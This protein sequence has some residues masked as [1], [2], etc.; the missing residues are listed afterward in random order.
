[1]IVASAVSLVF[2]NVSW[3]VGMPLAFVL[4]M[5][6]VRLGMDGVAER[7]RVGRT[8]EAE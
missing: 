1:L 7:G 6:L 4:H 3:F 5:V 8:V 2:L